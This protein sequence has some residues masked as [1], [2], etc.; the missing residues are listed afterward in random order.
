LESYTFSSGSRRIFYSTAQ[1]Y[2]DESDTTNEA[3]TM[4]IPKPHFLLFCDGNASTASESANANRGRWKFVLE[5]VE[6]GERSEATDIEPSFA[7]ERCALVSVLRGLESLE[8]P[9]RVTLV[10]TSRYVTRGLQYGLTEWRDNDF[11]WEHFGAVQPIRNADIWR[12]IDRT[13]AFHQVQCRWMSQEELPP[14]APS[15]DLQKPAEETIQKKIATRPSS[16]R[17]V[18]IASVVDTKTVPSHSNKKH[19]RIYPATPVSSTRGPVHEPA[20]GKKTPNSSLPSNATGM[21]NA[22][23]P[24]IRSLPWSRLVLIV[25][26]PWRSGRTAYRYLWNRILDLDECLE[27][28]IKC[29]LLLEPTL[30]RPRQKK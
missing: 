26:A 29:L 19:Q 9:S 21:P 18:T 25:S 4:T 10:T 6:T 15:E 30:Q 1:A 11:S 23:K 2:A 7:T 24:K 8:Q 5:N 22:E 13:L 3:T 28:F 16:P 12:R 27:S 20:L 14:E 17:S